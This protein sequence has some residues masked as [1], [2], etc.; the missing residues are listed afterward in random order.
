MV[1]VPFLQESNTNNSPPLKAFNKTEM[2]G[3]LSTQQAHPL[4]VQKLVKK[5]EDKVEK[6]GSERWFKIQFNLDKSPTA[7]SLFL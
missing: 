5:S 7:R 6:K 3:F 4:F 1:T 2:Q